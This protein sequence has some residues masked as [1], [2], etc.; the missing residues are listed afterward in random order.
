MARWR[1]DRYSTLQLDSF[2]TFFQAAM[3]ALQKAMWRVKNAKDGLVN[4]FNDSISALEEL[5]GP[6]TYHPLA[7]EARRDISASLRKAGLCAYFGLKR[8]PELREMSMQMS[9]PDAPPSPRRRQRTMISFHYR[10]R[11]RQMEITSQ[12][13][14]TLT[15]RGGFI[16]YLHRFKLKNS[17]YCV[18]DPVKIQDVLQILK[19]YSMC[20]RVRVALEAEIGVVFGRRNFPEI[21]EDGISRVKF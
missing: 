10:R 4:V 15:G 5:T 13:A 11:K 18:C 3:V 12:I 7:H 8:M 17:P 1:G 19:E 6:K 9:S 20:L 16:Q 2:C 21:M 14:Q